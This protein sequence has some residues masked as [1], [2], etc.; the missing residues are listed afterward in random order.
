MPQAMHREVMREVCSLEH[1][2][3]GPARLLHHP[4]EQS[5]RELGGQARTA[6][7]LPLIELLALSERLDAPLCS[8]G[9]KMLAESFP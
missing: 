8:E 1:A 3:H 5:P 2:P 9:S 4:L 7:P 6:H